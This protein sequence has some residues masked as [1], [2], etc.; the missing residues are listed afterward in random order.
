M[1]GT[2]LDQVSDTAKNTIWALLNR[3]NWGTAVKPDFH[4]EV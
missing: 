1:K 2:V 4:T 3:N